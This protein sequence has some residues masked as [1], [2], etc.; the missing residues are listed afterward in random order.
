MKEFKVQAWLTKNQDNEVELWKNKPTYNET[1]D[2]WTEAIPE[3]VGSDIF[4]NLC[5][6]LL[7]KG[8]CIQIEITRIG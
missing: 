2:E 5:D 8:E 4:D 7:D 6:G 1:F 3:E